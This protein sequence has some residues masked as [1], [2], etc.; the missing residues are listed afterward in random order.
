MY[1]GLIY[2]FPRL[3]FIWNLY[4]PVLR[5]RTLGSTAG[6]ERRTGNC[7]QAG[8]GGS[9]LTFPSAPVVEPRVHMNDQH[10]NFQFG[11][12]GIINGNN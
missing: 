2:L 4:F 3:V 10:K 11:K 1:L 12:L 5:E 9:S 8:V 7:C 6:A